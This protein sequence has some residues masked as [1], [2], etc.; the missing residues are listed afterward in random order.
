MNLKLDEKSEN[1][2]LSMCKMERELL[3]IEPST[4]QQLTAAGCSGS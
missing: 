4:Q 1:F 3:E 2:C